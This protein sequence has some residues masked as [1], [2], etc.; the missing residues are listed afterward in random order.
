MRLRL[1]RLHL[2][3]RGVECDARRGRGGG[4]LL[5]ELLRCM[6]DRRGAE[7]LAPLVVEDEVVG[8]GHLVALLLLQRQQQLLPLKPDLHHHLREHL[9]VDGAEL[10]HDLVGRDREVEWQR[11]DKPAVLADLR[12]GD[13]LQ[14]VDDEH[15]RDQVLD[16]VRHVPRQREDATLDLFEEVGY[17]LVVE[18]QRAAEEGVEDDTARP[19]VDLGAGVELAGD[20]L[21][22]GIVG[23][24]AARLEEVAILH[25][26][27]QPKVGDPQL[28]VGVEQQVFRLEVTVDD[29][30]LVAVL[31]A[32]NELLEHDAR[33]RL[34]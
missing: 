16:V 15:A 6:H 11:D 32:R 28:L 12:D 14:R 9:V 23:R 21:G 10:T 34:G 7:H 29:H 2:L 26:V 27:R 22:G 30:M 17:V 24:A 18:R 3:L 20:D 25:H 4:L 8:N 13:P 31:H 33:A 1:L 5:R 19:D